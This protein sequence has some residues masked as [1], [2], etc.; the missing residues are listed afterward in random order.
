M[1]AEMTPLHQAFC[2]ACHSQL[3][4]EVAYCPYCRERLAPSDKAL[5]EKAAAPPQLS[6]ISAPVCD[7]EGVRE[8]PPAEDVE[9]I[10]DGTE[11]TVPVSTESAVS[12]SIEQ[13]PRVIPKRRG[14]VVIAIAIFLVSLVGISMWLYN[15]TRSVEKLRYKS[16][17]ANV[18]TRSEPNVNR[19]PVSK[20]VKP[21][22]PT[23][24]VPSQVLSARPSFRCPG[25]GNQDEITICANT[26][27]AEMDNQMMQ[28]YLALAARQPNRRIPV[29]ARA[30]ARAALA[31][32]RACGSD[33]GCIA[34][35]LLSEKN[36]FSAY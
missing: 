12:G 11:N 13:G 17:T 18:A 7:V 24:Q 6:G 5:R 10:K 35:I 15:G 4:R 29:K 14:R 20:R 3:A 31:N 8:Q 22:V 19:L 28:A 9:A 16:D 32:R 33:V 1:I 21:P 2:S 25:E 34:S 27:L 26:D 23:E 30:Y 36:Y